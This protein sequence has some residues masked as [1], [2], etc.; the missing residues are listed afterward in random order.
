MLAL[1]KALGL[2]APWVTSRDVWQALSPRIAG[3]ALWDFKWDSL[4]SAGRRRG[5]TPLA[6]GTVD[7]RMGGQRERLAPEGSE[8]AARA[9]AP[10]AW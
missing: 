5:F 6:A 8:D 2:E 9:G 7:G 3:V 4:P 10:V 1:G